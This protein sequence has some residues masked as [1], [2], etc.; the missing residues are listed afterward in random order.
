[1]IVSGG[2]DRE[3]AAGRTFGVVSDNAAIKAAW[4][5]ATEVNNS[6]T[7]DKLGPDGGGVA[8]GAADEADGE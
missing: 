7:F 5:S 6:S 4:P 2:R 3:P 1:M 8:V